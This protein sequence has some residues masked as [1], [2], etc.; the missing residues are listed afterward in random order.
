MSFFGEEIVPWEEC[1]EKKREKE[2]LEKERGEE[3][4]RG[5]ESE[6]KRR[7]M[8]KQERSYSIPVMDT[9]RRGRERRDDRE[10]RHKTNLCVRVRLC[11]QESRVL[12]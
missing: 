6:G 10:R 1:E 9:Q 7:N 3:E 11:V 8:D 4:R 5:E 12:S 2:G